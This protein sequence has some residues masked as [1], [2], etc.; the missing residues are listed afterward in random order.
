MAVAPGRVP[1][2]EPML[3]T[4]VREVPAD[5]GDWAAEAKWDGAR[6]LAYVS[7]GAVVL[8]GRSGRDVTA[9]YPK[10]QKL[11][12]TGENLQVGW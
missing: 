5:D 10:S 1:L 4:A 6:V 11:H 2:I 8:R 12:Q 7:G 3:A 9:S